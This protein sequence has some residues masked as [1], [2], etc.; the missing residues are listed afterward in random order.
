MRKKIQM[1]EELDDNENH[2]DEEIEVKNVYKNAEVVAKKYIDQFFADKMMHCGGKIPTRYLHDP[3]TV[4]MVVNYSISQAVDEA[5]EMLKD[6]IT[7]KEVDIANKYGDATR[8]IKLVRD[9]LSI[10]GYAKIPKQFIGGIMIMYLRFVE[11]VD[12]D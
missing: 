1:D 3:F 2:Q 9:V 7:D 4:N 11:G 10:C 6:T 8:D 5:Y 12:F